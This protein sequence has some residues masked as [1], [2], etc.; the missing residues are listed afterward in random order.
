MGG[1]R[2][3]PRL[4]PVNEDARRR[5]LTRKLDSHDWIKQV[6]RA[7]LQ[8]YIRDDLG[9]R[10]VTDP[11]DNQ[12]QCFALGASMPQFY[13]L[14]KMSG[15]KSKIILDLIR[16]RKRRGELGRAI[17]CVPQL[18][19]VASW[20][21]QIRTHAPDLRYRLLVGDK[22]ERTAL[23]RH[24]TDL[25]VI[26]YAGLLPY[27]T[28]RTRNKRKDKNEQTIEKGRAGEFASLFN[29]TA[30]DET[31]KL[32]GS[33]NLYFDC[34]WWLSVASDFCYGSTG[35]AFGRDPLPLWSQFM[36]VDKGLTLGSTLTAFR[37]AFYTPKK[38]WFSGVKYTFDN[39]LTQ[40]LH[41]IIKHR[42]IVYEMEEFA[43]LPLSIPIRIPVR[44]TGEGAAFYKRC[45]DGLAEAQGDYRTLDS[46]FT[47]MRQC[48]SGFISMRADDASRVQVIFKDNPKLDALRE[49]VLSKENE[50]FL[51]FHDFIISGQMIEGMLKEAKVGYAALRGGTK[52]PGEQYQRFLKDPKCRVFVLN[53]QVGAESINPQYVCRCA[54]FYESPAD[55]KQR[56]Q[57]EFRIRRQ[58]QKWRTF[59]YDLLVQG[60]V[61]QKIAR[62]N[63]EGRNLLKAVE[64]GE[65]FIEEGIDKSS[66]SSASSGP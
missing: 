4:I 26:N 62:Y 7:E 46:I 25:C 41:R 66:G 5:Y 23:L 15:G 42:S 48:A 24:P 18:L 65:I 6:P 11:W 54:V 13:Y 64:S 59:I 19:H 29:F 35:T 34:C 52:D 20:E 60:T 45:R 49:L 32:L 22:D 33:R 61:E 56:Q 38:D 51:V 47:R 40:D 9:Y 50:K 57:A 31:H 39:A 30:M 2:R 43:D 27:M 36:L 16:H 28:H 1:G 3:R 14:L 58:G 53:N 10:F 44:L 37:N 21:E 63:R 17:V 8:K 55:P 12:L